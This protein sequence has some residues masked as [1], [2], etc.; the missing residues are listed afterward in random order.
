MILGILSAYSCADKA[1][2]FVPVPEMI[3]VPVSLSAAGTETKRLEPFDPEFEN[4]IYDIWII[5]YSERGIILTSNHYRSDV[6][7]GNMEVSLDANFIKAKNCTIC[8]L[9]NAGAVGSAQKT[10]FT[11][12]LPDDWVWPDNILEYRQKFVDVSGNSQPDI[13]GTAIDKILM[14]GYF[15]GDVNETMSVSVSLGRM[16]CRV[17]LVLENQLGEDLAS[18][19]TWLDYVPKVSYI[20]PD[21]K[22]PL[23]DNMYF[24]NPGGEA[25]DTFTDNLVGTAAAPVLK[26]NESVTFYYYLTPNI[27][28]SSDYATECHVKATTVSGTE[29]S[30]SIFLGNDMPGSEERDYC[31]YPNDFY[32]FT[33]HLKK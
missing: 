22:H 29:L 7:M 9:A 5:Q 17:N 12:V 30:G 27:C 11:G 13:P 3:T 31:L 25:F 24:R 20:F 21:V 6:Q 2:D 28:A 4:L 8:F 1:V 10:G 16:M 18:I 33:V 32:T 19:H 15:I 23:P 26:N 14:N